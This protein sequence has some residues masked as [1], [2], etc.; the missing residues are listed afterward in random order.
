GE[1]MRQISWIWTE[2]GISGTDL[3]L[4]DA[5]RIEWAKAYARMRRWDEEVQLLQ[6]F[7]RLPISFEHRAAAWM[8]R[9]RAV[10]LQT[11]PR[12]LAQ[13]MWAYAVRQAK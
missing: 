12:E 11:M 2:A 13:G 3:E 8:D 4:E 1:N 5:L 6:E 9:A 10:E 7:R